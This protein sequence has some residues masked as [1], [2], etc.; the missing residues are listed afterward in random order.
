MKMLT[1]LV[2]SLG[3]TCA[4]LGAGCTTPDTPTTLEGKLARHGFAQGEPIRELKNYRIDG[5]HYLDSEHLIFSAGPS[6]DYMVTLSHR[7]SDLRAVEDIAF[8]STNNNLT[9]FEKVV[10]ATP[11][12]RR[13]CQIKSLHTLNKLEQ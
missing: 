8:T 10:M 4:L 13:D 11:T 12:G 2:P 9:A 5:W 6:G 7:C 3:L 1:K